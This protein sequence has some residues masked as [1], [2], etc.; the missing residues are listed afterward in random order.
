MPLFSLFLFAVSI[1][2]VL[3]MCLVSLKGMANRRHCLS[4]A[5]TA[6]DREIA[7]C[8]SPSLLA[9]PVASVFALQAP[10]QLQMIFKANYDLL[11]SIFNPE[12]YLDIT[13][14]DD[15][16]RVGRDDKGNLFLLERCSP[17]LLE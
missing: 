5:S 17:M 14:V 4:K 15:E 16:L 9:S 13:Y 12:G 6:Y 10:T 1:S 11:L 2:S 7:S 3:M 8:T